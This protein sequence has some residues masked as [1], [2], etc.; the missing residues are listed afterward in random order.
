LAVEKLSETYEQLC[1]ANEEKSSERKTLDEMKK[2]SEEGSERFMDS[3]KLIKN[4]LAQKERLEEKLKE[5]KIYFLNLFSLKN[6]KMG[7]L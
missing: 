1:I 3:L 2:K 6:I 4:L 7:I 5:G